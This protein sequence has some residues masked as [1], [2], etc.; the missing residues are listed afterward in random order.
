MKNTNVFRP[1]SKLTYRRTAVFVGL[2]EQPTHPARNIHLQNL[3][4]HF[5]TSVQLTWSTSVRNIGFSLRRKLFLTLRRCQ[6]LYVPRIPL[7]RSPSR[8]GRETSPFSTPST[9]LGSRFIRILCLQPYTLLSL[10]LCIVCV[11]G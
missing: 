4:Q 9:P 2:P 6:K 5:S 1:A 10:Y 8:L 7:P 3:Q 11:R